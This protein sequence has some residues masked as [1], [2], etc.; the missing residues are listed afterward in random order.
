MA[1]PDRHDA[2]VIGSGQAGCRMA[3]ALVDAG[4]STVLL[5]PGQARGMYAA[6][7]FR[8]KAL[9]ASARVAHLARR[10]ADYGVRTGTVSVDLE[11]VRQRMRAV[12]ERLQQMDTQRLLAA[13]SLKRVAGEPRF[14]GRDRVEVRMPDDTVRQLSAPRI[15]IDCVSR[16]H[17]PEVQ[18]LS[19]VP[20]LDAAAALDLE[21]VPEHLLVLGGGRAGLELAQMFR[22]FGSRVSI[23]ERAPQLLQGE[24]RDV[25]AAMA[26]LLRQDGIQVFL[27][28][29]VREARCT[30][31]GAIALRLRFP[32]GDRVVAGSHLLLAAGRDV[33]TASLRL[34]AAGVEVD[35]R[36]RIR[37]NEHL[38][39]SVP[40]IY[41]LGESRSEAPGGQPLDDVSLLSGELPGRDG[42]GAAGRL[43][44]CFVFTDPPL[45]RL[46]LTEAQARQQRFAVRIAR[47]PLSQTAPPEESP[48]FAK[49]IVDGQSG[50]ILGAAVLALEG[51][52]ILPL[53]QMAMAGRVGPAALRDS[54]LTHSAGGRT[55]G[56]LFASLERIDGGRARRDADGNEETQGMA[57]VL[58]GIRAGRKESHP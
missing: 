19:A 1:E 33:D 32:S 15:F 13:P 18:G 6:D 14:I 20:F 38:Q 40:G 21:T 16:A 31:N 4:M 17:L 11:R 45:G 52:E 30:D 53:L 50:R 12:I 28:A 58:S 39:S 34:D 24:D 9:H 35:G 43:A 27:E 48:G 25:A 47:L 2:L 3:L 49:V 42:P 57:G 41:A 23:F 55:L 37:V 26:E 46:G 56:L 10:A 54:V 44:G 8:G 29:D 22:R 5:M 7:G 51:A 36:G